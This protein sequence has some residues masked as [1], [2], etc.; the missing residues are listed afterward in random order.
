M[1]SE[2]RKI[3][4]EK[5]QIILSNDNEIYFLVTSKSKDK[6]NF[7]DSKCLSQIKPEIIYYKRTKNG[8]DS[9]LI[10][11]VFKL[12]VN[13]KEKNNKW[14]KYLI[15]YEIEEEFYEILLD[16]KENIFIYNVKFQKYNKYINNIEQKDIAQNQIKIQQK[17]E[18]FLE[19]LKKNNENNKIEKLYEEGIELYKSIKNFSFL[20]FLFLKLYNLNIKLCSQ[21][22][23]T[24]KEINDKGNFDRDKGL[25]TELNTFNQIYS[26][27][28]NIIEKYKYNSISFYGIIFCYLNS[29]DTD[30]FSN[31]I[32]DFSKEN[33][34]ILYEILITYYSHLKNPLNQNSEF[35]T[36]FIKYAI[37]KGEKYETFNK[38]LNYISDIESFLYVLN[39]NKFE[40][41][42]RY[43]NLNSKPIKLTSDLKLIKIEYKE[44]NQINPKTEI[45]NIIEI[46]E[47]LFEFSSENSILLIY[48]EPSFWSF[49]LKQ[50]NKSEII[51]I[52]NCY[53][54]RKI[55]K[56]YK[57]LINNLYKNTTNK[58]EL[59]IK[60]EINRYNDIDAFAFNLNKNIKKMLEL[61]K[62]KFND[63]EKLGI[64]MKYNP[65]YSGETEEDEIKYQNLRQTDIF[66]YIDFKNPSK[67]FQKAFRYL[68]FEEI[69]SGKINEFIFKITS[70]IIDISSLGTVIEIIDITRLNQESSKIYYCNI[71]KDKYEFI[72]KNKLENLKEGKELNKA[73]QILSNFICLIFDV[74]KNNNFL[75]E[76]IKKLDY[77]LQKLIYFELIKKGKE[78]YE[79]KEYIF[80]LFLSNLKEHDRIIELIRILN[81]KD[82]E[83]F[84][85][86]LMEVCK[87]EK[88]EFYSNYE[89][90][91]IKLLCKLNE[92]EKP[93]IT[94]NNCS[95][96]IQI[97]LDNI[98][99]DL[100]KN[101]ITKNQL[102]EFLN[103]KNIDDKIKINEDIYNNSTIQKLFLIKIII[104]QYD[105]IGKY[106]YLKRLLT[107]IN[108]NINELN[109][110]KNCLFIFHKNIYRNQIRNLI[111]IINDLKTKKI[112]KFYT[113]SIQ[114]DIQ[115][116]LRLKP[117]CDEINKIKDLLFFK[118]IFEKS[119]GKDEKERFIDA[120]NIL[121]K[122]KQLFEEQKYNIEEIFKFDFKE[123]KDSKK[124]K[125]IFE[126]IKDEISKKD[127]LYSDKFINQMISYLNIIDE[128]SQRYFIILIKS[129]KFEIIVKSIK[130]FIENC[131]NKQLITLTK[132]LE[133]SNM[134]LTDL[135]SI[136]KDLKDKNIFDYNY[137]SSSYKIFISFNNK[138]ESIDFLLNQKKNNFDDLK[139]KLSPTYR[140][141]SIKDIDDATECLIQFKQ[142]INKDGLEIIEYIKNLDEE[143]INTIINYS[144][145]YSSI[146]DLDITNEKDNFET[147]Y[148]I[149]EN[150][151]LNFQLYNEK[152]YYKIDNREIQINLKELIDLKNKI[153][154]LPEKNDIKVNNEIKDIQQIKYDKLKYFKDIMT[155]VEEIY[156]KI[157]LIRKKGY[158]I[159][160][161]ISIEMK[162]PKIVYLLDDEE[163]DFI[164]I[165]N[166]LLTIIYYYEN[167]MDTVYKSQKY[168]RFLYGKLFLRIKWYLEG[169]D[170]ISDIIRYIL[171]KTD[172]KYKIEQGKIYNDHIYLDTNYKENYNEYIKAIIDNM[173]MYICSLF[174]KNK[175]DFKIHYENMKIK[176]ENN[177]HGF[178]IY[179]CENYILEEFILYLF[180]EKLEQLPIAQNILFL[181]NET[182]YEEM[183]SFF[184]RAILC[185]HNTLF[186]IEIF[187]SISILHLEKMFR[188]IDE[189]LSYK[190]EI[191]K[192]ANRHYYN[193]NKLNTNSY[194]K[195]C[196]FFI[197][198][199][200]INESTLI[201]ELEKY[202]L[203]KKLKIE[204][205]SKDDDNNYKIEGVKIFCSEMCGLGK[206][207]KI[208][209][210][211]KENKEKYYFFPLGGKLSKNIISKKLR[212]VLEQIKQDGNIYNKENV[213]EYNNP[214]IHLDIKETEDIQVLNEFLFSFFITK[215]YTNNDDIIYI[216]SNIKIYVEIPNSNDNYLSKI[217]LLK[218]CEIDNITF[219]N[220]PK[221]ELD[222][223]TKIIFKRIIGAE[224]DEQIEEFIKNNIGIKNYSYHQIQIFI[225]MIKTQF[226][227]LS[228]LYDS[229]N[230]DENKFIIKCCIENTNMQNNTGL[231]LFGGDS[232]INRELKFIDPLSYLKK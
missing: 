185:D 173:E 210:I 73:I 146:I 3:S 12:A 133:L 188:Y 100:E 182:S 119:K 196:I 45:D 69:F 72:I 2:S 31:I 219:E 71:L 136:L 50:Y 231:C 16:I 139:K 8:K 191:F 18:L 148:I 75:E 155:N 65:Y 11:H 145:N 41:C 178:Y 141:I 207:F 228:R 195:S 135:K 117:L 200:L 162:Y 128:N 77:K 184:Y 63:I 134:N 163:K 214:S 203:K 51:Y 55:F 30:N 91:K 226:N 197:Y 115:D 105:V 102:E 209:K 140:I 26:I 23:D 144:K 82:K 89:N 227:L 58:H 125:N 153:F 149:I 57:D 152:C 53:H 116:L 120:L 27:S 157:K 167:Q 60:D 17:F 101:L 183:K 1:S 215:F 138:R 34:Q 35:Y 103:I 213:F 230:D 106:N 123:K 180:Q 78:K 147:L 179:K 22:I 202:T 24:F 131:F 70:K 97:V 126:S 130:F 46:L 208:R 156:E 67:G 211:I 104:P 80:D 161:L 143:T 205:I 38:V 40:I 108:N 44:E 204:D 220:L 229:K 29:Y 59:N 52:D 48:L 132:D 74:E 206:S 232:N 176:V 13:K 124:I 217:G 158:L 201:Y 92:L 166:H 189:I 39:E 221:L 20:I 111:N 127:E 32:Y 199:N 154:I 90:N 113:D 193:I 168:L 174:S 33:S 66:D 177:Y 43:D 36:N 107:D 151:K 121:N 42:K 114:Q 142:L 212:E 172:Y 37:N 6:I 170:E 88:N 95:I 187:E 181:S 192:K 169:N 164:F 86:K 96:K 94:E 9:F 99:T 47:K 49:L 68:N 225:K 64:I 84:I 122:I 137:K 186:I 56:K 25:I 85:V 118:K 218:L 28:N 54:L 216:P 223:E 87:F 109:Y 198:K 160:F 21:L 4:Y 150:A 15:Q 159:P 76:K 129:K 79:I 112:K 93:I 175:L 14:I 165:K 83:K 98:I 19:A 7:F 5:N 194:L 224:N 110:I 61:N 190:F 10:N 81:D 62:N 222:E 171:N